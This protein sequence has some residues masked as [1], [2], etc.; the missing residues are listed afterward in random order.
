MI[1]FNPAL[2][3]PLSCFGNMYRASLK[4]SVM[5]KFAMEIS[6]GTLSFNLLK[7]LVPQKGSFLFTMGSHCDILFTVSI[8][9]S[10][11]LREYSL[12]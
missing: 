12:T 6:L 1:I 7:V 2:V 9:K 5:D 4:F 10:F 3:G 8:F 11:S